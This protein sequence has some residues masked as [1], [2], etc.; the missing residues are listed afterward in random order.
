MTRARNT[1]RSRDGQFSPCENKQKWRTLLTFSV[2]NAIFW[3]A[4]HIYMHLDDISG[5]YNINLPIIWTKYVQVI[6][7]LL[8]N[9]QNANPNPENEFKKQTT[10]GAMF[11]VVLTRYK[12]IR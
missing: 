8:K 4:I 2:E 1:N 10:N 6:L 3:A 9:G 7:S 12:M 11:F 5:F